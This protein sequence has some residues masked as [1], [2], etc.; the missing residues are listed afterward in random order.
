MERKP[1][2][3]EWK[4]PH[5]ISHTVNLIFIMLNTSKREMKDKEFQM[6]QKTTSLAAG[7]PN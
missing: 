1:V 2:F 7:N 5:I 3:S 6:K 4:E